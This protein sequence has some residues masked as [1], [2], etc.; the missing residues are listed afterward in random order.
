[1]SRDPRI[2][3][4]LLATMA[5]TGCARMSLQELRSEPPARA[6]EFNVDYSALG[7]CTLSALQAGPVGGL[8]IDTG[9]LS[10]E[11][12]NI[13]SEHRMTVTGKSG[14]LSV[15]DLTFQGKTVTGTRV[16]SRWG[17][18]FS[19]DPQDGRRGGR[20]IDEKAWP[21]VYECAKRLSKV[22]PNPR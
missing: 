3:A 13:A 11:T 8:F 21:V 14:D 15:I 17:A 16:E 18:A 12:V 10:Y 22:A 7:N 20:I 19:G 4:S 5:L 9:N 1:M 2:I 6:E